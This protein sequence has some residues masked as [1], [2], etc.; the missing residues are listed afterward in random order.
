MPLRN[1]WSI[2]QGKDFQFSS[3]SPATAHPQLL[4][5]TTA[6]A[7]GNEKGGALVHHFYDHYARAWLYDFNLQQEGIL[8]IILQ[9]SAAMMVYVLRGEAVLKTKPFHTAVLF[10][11]SYSLLSLEPG[12]HAITAPPGHCRILFFQLTSPLRSL[13]DET[14]ITI[15]LQGHRPGRINDTC[16]QL[17][18]S[19][20]QTR[21]SGEIWQLKRQVTVLDL[22]FKTLDEI[23]VT[24]R[25]NQ[26]AAR[27]RDYDTF[28]Q[29]KEYVQANVHKKLSLQTL[30][31]R[32]SIQPTLLRRGY[33]KVF[34]HHLC[35]F[36]RE[37][38]LNR[39]LSLLQHTSLPVHEIAWEVGYESSTSFTR[40]FTTHFQ[41]SPT[42]YRRNIIRAM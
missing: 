41:Q 12:Q 7:A 22:L 35:D 24:Y 1:T 18:L 15:P 30:A 42:D 25:K 39:A 38:R 10:E 33:K 19:L 6:A 27:H 36:I 29:V 40:V 9:Q 2:L 37:V 3:L 17:L 11:N 26:A 13:L 28:K 31:S 14:H 8:D 32:F 5:D 21:Y 34:H 16:K 4:S 23:G 20:Y